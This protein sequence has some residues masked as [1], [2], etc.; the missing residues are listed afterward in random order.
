MNRKPSSV[1]LLIGLHVIAF[2]GLVVLFF[3]SLNG[4]EHPLFPSLAMTGLGMSAL[5]FYGLLS[6]NVVIYFLACGYY[7][8]IAMAAA[9]FLIGS[10]T[11]MF[12]I[13]V[14]IP[15]VA[16]VMSV[17][18]MV[19]F[20]LIGQECRKYFKLMR[21]RPKNRDDYHAVKVFGPRD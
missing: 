3:D 9:L 21:K 4:F 20:G 10:V 16:T 13:R 17:A 18:T 1:K 5:I 19:L 11:G 15:L 8:T 14:E 12:L 7:G 6:K 2:A